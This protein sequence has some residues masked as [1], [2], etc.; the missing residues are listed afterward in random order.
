M[1]N[2]T[3]RYNDFKG[4]DLA[5]ELIAKIPSKLRQELNL[6]ID[7]D[8]VS[9]SDQI[10]N[11]NSVQPITDFLHNPDI[12]VLHS[13]R[14]LDPTKKE[15]LEIM[16]VMTDKPYDGY[17]PKSYIQ[18]LR[19]TNLLIFNSKTNEEYF[20]ETSGH[21]AAV[22]ETINEARRAKQAKKEGKKL[23][24][25][26]E[27]IADHINAHVLGE[28]FGR[29][30][31]AYFSPI[32]RISDCNWMPV[33]GSKVDEKMEEL[34]EWY[35]NGS[36]NLHPIIKSAILHAEFIKIHPFPDGN[37]RTARLLS[38]YE[39]VKNGYPAITIKARNKEEYMASLDKA[40]TTGDISDLVRLFTERMI[41]RQKLYHEK[42]LEYSLADDIE[43]E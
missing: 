22:A 27:F 32:A 20:I 26:A 28:D 14:Y 40:V 1:Q 43:R 8:F 25:T 16:Q 41:A 5:N 17:L 11:I 33:N 21:L 9:N 24:L 35:N 23:P 3:N 6:M 18:Y 38:N 7:I 10:E 19:D 31:S 34:L 39:L 42:L 37:G 4:I 2:Y 29:F 12:K 13:N 36:E 15:D 30:R